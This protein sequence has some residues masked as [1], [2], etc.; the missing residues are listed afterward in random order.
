MPISCGKHITQ[1]KEN[2]DIKPLRRYIKLQKKIMMSANN[3][4]YVN[5]VNEASFTN[6]T[7]SGRGAPRDSQ[8]VIQRNPYGVRVLGK[9]ARSKNKRQS[10][11]ASPNGSSINVP[12]TSLERRMEAAQG[13]RTRDNVAHLR[14]NQPSPTVAGQLEYPHP[15]RKRVR[16]GWESKTVLSWYYWSFF[17]EKM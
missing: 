11:P 2:S 12:V 1:E 5:A 14:V 3:E 15:H 6:G 13:I 7:S 17:N 9:G 4:R 10:P 8:V 16:I